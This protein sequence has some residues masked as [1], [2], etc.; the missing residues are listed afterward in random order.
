M[1]HFLL[2]PDSLSAL[3]LKHLVAAEGGKTDGSF[4]SG[5]SNY[6]ALP[7]FSNVDERRFFEIEA[8][9]NSWK[10]KRNNSEKSVKKFTQVNA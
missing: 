3:K 9:D 8:H 4:F 7:T 10:I 2:T 1:K 5:W 6:V